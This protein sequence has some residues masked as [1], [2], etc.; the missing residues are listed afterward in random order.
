MIQRQSGN[1][2]EKD[3]ATVSIHKSHSDSG[4]RTIKNCKR[5]R[6]ANCF[7]SQK[8]FRFMIQ[9]HTRNVGEKEKAIVFIQKNHSDS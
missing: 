8:P 6:K 7:H 3:K 5:E 9:S 1:V 4:F 2:R